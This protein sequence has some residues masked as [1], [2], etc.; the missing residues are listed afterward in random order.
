MDSFV[1]DLNPVTNIKNSKNSRVAWYFWTTRMQ[2]WRGQEL[3]KTTLASG[4][5]TI[6]ATWPAHIAVL[7]PRISLRLYLTSE[8]STS[9]SYISGEFSLTIL[10]SFLMGQ[11]LVHNNFELLK[12]V[13]FYLNTQTKELK[14]NIPNRTHPFHLV[15]E[16]SLP[17]FVSVT[18]LAIIFNF[19]MWMMVMGWLPS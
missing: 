5:E 1:I 18:L 6:H 7:A 15:E 9:A 17:I 11:T 10:F 3:Q 8:Q 14:A 12:N 16:S 2:P 4:P 19:V 13:Q